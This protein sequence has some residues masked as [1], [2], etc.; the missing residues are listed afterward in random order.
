VV[1][2]GIG[3]SS[4]GTKALHD[5]V[6][7][8]FHSKEEHQTKLLFVDT[9]DADYT[10]DVLRLAESALEEGEE[11]VVN[12]ICKSGSTVESLALGR[13]F[14]NLLKKHR[15]DYHKFCCCDK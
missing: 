13:V 1:V 11:I 4:L 6:N 5:A 7:G 10:F 2:V 12:L 8:Y 15:K 3:G 14:V 9:V